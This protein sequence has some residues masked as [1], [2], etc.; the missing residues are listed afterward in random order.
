VQG[1]PS[2]LE[3]TFAQPKHDPVRGAGHASVAGDDEEQQRGAQLKDDAHQQEAQK[4]KAEQQQ[5]DR[6]A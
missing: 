5:A 6:I 3:P 1:R 2:P 4:L